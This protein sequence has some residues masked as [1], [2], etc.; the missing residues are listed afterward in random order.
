MEDEEQL[1]SVDNELTEAMANT[2]AAY[3]AVKVNCNTKEELAILAEIDELLPQ[4]RSIFGEARAFAL[5]N[6]NG[7]ALEV[8]VTRGKPTLKQLTTSVE[9]LISLNERMGESTSAFL[10]GVIIVCV[11]LMVVVIIAV[12]VFSMRFASSVAKIFADPITHVKNASAQ[13]ARGNLNVAVEKMYPDE[14]GEMTESFV[15]AIHMMQT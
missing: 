5:K 15:E 11:V 7:E 14:I 1:Q 8:L 10:T 2:D 4:Y 3:E 12:T 6:Q 13:L 9:S